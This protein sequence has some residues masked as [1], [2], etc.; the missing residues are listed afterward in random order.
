MKTVTIFWKGQSKSGNYYLGVTFE[1]QGFI[2]K[3]FIQVTESKFGELPEEG[4]IKVP[5]SALA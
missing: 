1:E 5:A 4:E 3:K 2:S